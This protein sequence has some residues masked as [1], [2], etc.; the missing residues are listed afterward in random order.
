V[1]TAEQELSLCNREG[2]YCIYCICW[3]TS[4]EEKYR[5]ER[6]RKRQLCSCSSLLNKA[7]TVSVIVDAAYLFWKFMV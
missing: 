1:T 5:V 7:Q 3:Y 2:G 6:K 4:R